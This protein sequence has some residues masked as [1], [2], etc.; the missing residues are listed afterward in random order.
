MDPKKVEWT[1][2][3]RSIFSS[4]EGASIASFDIVM[5]LTVK[6]DYACRA[7]TQ[8]AKRY[9]CGL[10]CSIDQVA[11]AEEIPAKYLAQILSDLR[12]GG[13]VESRRGKQGGYLLSKEPKEISLLDVVSPAQP[14]AKTARMRRWDRVGRKPG[15][16]IMG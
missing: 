5:K 14:T 15:G 13:L 1:P 6:L 3:S 4:L 11:E 12:Q 2:V 9:E 7:M 16:N 8:L 10:V